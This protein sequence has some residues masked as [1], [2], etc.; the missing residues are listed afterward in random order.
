MN[1]DLE[2]SLFDSDH[3]I[4]P[5]ATVA[6]ARKAFAERPSI[7]GDD[8]LAWAL[9]RDG[10]CAAALPHA[11]HALRLGTK[12]AL[13]FFHRGWIENCLGMR[14]ASHRDLEARARAS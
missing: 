13:K 4:T 5:T 9:A 6:L 3:H 10:Q 14:A 2:I 8:A 11:N 1:S 12:D 7:D